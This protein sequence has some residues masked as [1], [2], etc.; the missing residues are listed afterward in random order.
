MI[1]GTLKDINR[2][3]ILNGRLKKGLDFL[4]SMKPTQLL[5]KEVG[6]FEREDIQGNEVFALHQVYHTRLTRVAKHESHRKHIDLQM[7]WKGSERIAVVPIKELKAVTK[8]DAKNDFIFYK[9][10]KGLEL[11]MSPGRLAILFPP[12]GH[13]P[14]L[15]FKKKDVV[16]KTVVKVRI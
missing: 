14:A 3:N 6:Y 7:I 4:V 13:A 16:Y 11:I 15:T 2:H 8:Y 9:Y 10:K 1:Y 12:D 5:K